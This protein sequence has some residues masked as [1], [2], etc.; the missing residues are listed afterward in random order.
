MKIFGYTMVKTE[1]LES[2]KKKSI[3]CD[4]LCRYSY[5]FNGD[6]RIAE[7]LYKFCRGEV[8]GCSIEGI[9]RDFFK[10]FNRDEWGRRI[11]PEVK[12]NE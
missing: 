4:N 1:H 2:L 3:V 8:H 7:L 5:W 6:K 12:E 11:N 10:S 9:R